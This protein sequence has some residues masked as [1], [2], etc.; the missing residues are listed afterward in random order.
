MRVLAVAS[1]RGSPNF[2]LR[3]ITGT[4]VPRTSIMPSS[5]SGAFGRRE[6][7]HMSKISRTVSTGRANVSRSIPSVTNCVIAFMVDSPTLGSAGA[8]TLELGVEG[9]VVAHVEGEAVT[10]RRLGSGS[11]RRLGLRS[12]GCGCR[13]GLRLGDL[14][15][16]ARLRWLGAG[17]GLGDRMVCGGR[18]ADV[19]LVADAEEGD[20]L[21]QV[22]GLV[23]ELLRRS[24]T[25][26]RQPRRSA[27]SPCRAAGSPG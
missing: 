16:H 27:G 22:L 7:S 26:P 3:S 13:E 4:H 6:I 25:S 15:V 17:C 23:G 24:P 2:V 12:L 1:V 10:G 19:R 11:G 21:L 8:L 20:G 9:V 5:C 14:L 18:L